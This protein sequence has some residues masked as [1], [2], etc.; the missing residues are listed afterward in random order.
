[1]VE[2]NLVLAGCKNGRG[3]CGSRKKWGFSVC[4]WEEEK[5]RI[6][7][8]LTHLKIS[9]NNLNLL[10]LI[11]ILETM[12]E[13]ILSLNMTCHDFCHVKPMNVRSMINKNHDLQFHGRKFNF[14]TL[15]TKIK[16]TYNFKDK[17]GYLLWFYPSI[18]EWTW[19]FILPSLQYFIFPNEHIEIF[20]FMEWYEPLLCNKHYLWEI[21]VYVIRI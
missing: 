11:G 9:R 2:K 3:I 8:F 12:L 10:I 21:N 19:C 20:H 7:D 16:Y 17:N 5:L 4:K 15:W 13:D 14:L 6:L 18:S 1:M